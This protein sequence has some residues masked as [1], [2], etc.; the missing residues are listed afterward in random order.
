MA[1]TFPESFQRT[2]GEGF[3]V[4]FLPGTSDSWVGNFERGLT[5]FDRALEHPN[6]YDILVIAGGSGY[7]VDPGRR[8]CISRFGDF[9]EGLW[10]IPSLNGIVLNHQGLAFE[11]IGEK[12]S[13]WHTRRLS[14][15][16]FTDLV[17]SDRFISG[18]AWSPLDEAWIDFEVDLMTGQSKGGAY[19][20]V[21]ATDWEHLRAQE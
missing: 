10:E 1:T 5:S 16:G 9:I 4:E 6:H 17:V 12:G 8:K 19:N 11:F 20:G 3:V 2:G 14:W 13:I 18:L 21:G 15:D 7:V